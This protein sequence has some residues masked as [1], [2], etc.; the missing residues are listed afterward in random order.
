MQ[1]PGQLSRLKLK[2]TERLELRN[3]PERRLYAMDNLYL[4]H[5]EALLRLHLPPRLLHLPRELQVKTS[6]RPDSKFVCRQ[7]DS[8]TLQLYQ[9]TLVSFLVH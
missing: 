2:L 9:A 5:P 1:R 7:V 6:K 3:L 4:I 8:L